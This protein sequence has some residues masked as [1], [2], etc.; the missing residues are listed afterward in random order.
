MFALRQRP[1][2]YGGSPLVDGSG[3]VAHFF[4]QKIMTGV[5]IHIGEYELFG[6]TF[7]FINH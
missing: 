2:T 6:N 4:R 3:G 7:I 5:V 1:V